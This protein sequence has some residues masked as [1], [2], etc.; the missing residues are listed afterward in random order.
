VSPVYGSILV[1][2]NSTVYRMITLVYGKFSPELLDQMMSCNNHTILAPDMLLS[3]L[4]L[5]FPVPREDTQYPDRTVFLVILRTRDF[6]RAFTEV[7]SSRY[8][9]L[10]VRI[11]SFHYPDKGFLFNVII[12]RP[13]D[14][15]E[16]A[17]AFLK[18]I[19]PNIT[20]TPENAGSLKTR[21]LTNKE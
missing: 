14:S 4:P 8:R 5:Q 9:D 11:L 10:D 15:R 2:T 7:V 3:G 6:N 13:F 17:L 18:T 21:D 20:A 12:D 16:Q 19:K 1:P